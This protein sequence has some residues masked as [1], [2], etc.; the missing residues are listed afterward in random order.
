MRNSFLMLTTNGGDPNDAYRIARLL[1]RV[2]KTFYL[3][4]PR[5]CKS[6]G[7]LIALGAHQI[8]MTMISELGARAARYSTPAA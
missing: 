8:Q 3:C 2:S 5:I 1:Q 4:V 7:T 6:A